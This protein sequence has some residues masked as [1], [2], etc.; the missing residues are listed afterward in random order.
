MRNFLLKN[1]FFHLTVVLFLA[2]TAW[3]ISLN[4]FN[5]NVLMEQKETWSAFY[6]TFAAFG[7][8]F[9]IFASR[10]L[11]FWRSVIGRAVLAFSAGL[12]L[13][14]IGQ[15]ID[16]YLSAIGNV[17]IFYPSIAE[18]GYTGSI[19]VYIYGSY[20]LARYIGINPSVR[21]FAKSRLVWF[22][23]V[24]MF[25]LSYFTYLHGYDFANA[26]TIHI[27]FDFGYPILQS[28][29]VA[30]AV[31]VLIRSRN[32]Q[33]GVLRRPISFLV[34]ALILQYIADSYFVYEFN[35]DKWYNANFNDYFYLVAYFVLA[36]SIIY[37]D[38]V[39]RD[40]HAKNEGLSKEAGFE[41]QSVEEL[42]VT[43]VNLLRT[44]IKSQEEIIG[45]LAWTEVAQIRNIVIKD[46]ENIELEISGDPKD[47]IDALLE[48][49]FKVFGPTAL[50][51]AKR[52]TY[53]ITKNMQLHQVPDKLR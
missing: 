21:N 9:G 1:H 52:N 3:W 33:G 27:I 53:R 43:Y 4:P 29:Y 49:F 6:W 30:L 20:L 16:S 37:I 31:Y 46:K 34:A 22:I 47:A 42:N 36:L 18:I 51:V 14:A 39:I 45:P 35:Q 50:Y 2:F 19:L 48:K 8:L 25:A 32:I 38:E 44:I 40:I 15:I 26:E 17:Y 28:I 23:P 41:S 13:Q 10:E 7:G 24:V 11:G 5:E 12:L